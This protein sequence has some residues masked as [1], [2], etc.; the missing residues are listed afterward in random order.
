MSKGLKVESLLKVACTE[1]LQVYE[2]NRGDFHSLVEECE[3]LDSVQP[4]LG[5][6]SKHPLVVIELASI[7]EVLKVIRNAI[8]ADDEIGEDE[9]EMAREV[10]EHS[11]YRLSFLDDY[12]DFE[13]LLDGQEVLDL[14]SQW[15]KDDSFYGGA[16]TQAGVLHS[17]LRDL[18][19]A[20]TLVSGDMSIF[21]TVSQVILLVSR[22]IISSDGISYE[23][24]EYLDKLTASYRNMQ[25]A[26]QNLMESYHRVPDGHEY[27]IDEVSSVT[28]KKRESQYSPPAP[29]PAEV[30]EKALGELRSLVGVEEVKA[31]V[32]RLVNFLKVRQQRIEAGLPMAMQSLHFVFTGN[33]G[34]GKTTVA[35]ILG[36]ILYGFGLLKT[37]TFVE[38]DRAGLVGG[39]VGQTAIKTTEVIAKAADGVLFID[40]AY[41]LSSNVGSGDQ[42]GQ[43]AIDV[44]LKKM[45]DM[46][47]RLVVIVAGYP[48]LM[49]QFLLSNPGLESRFTRFINF[50]DYYVSD[51]CRIFAGMAKNNSYKLTTEARGN[52]ALLFNRAFQTKQQNFGNA[53]FVRNV[54][55]QT[56]GNH[57][58]RLSNHA[59][60]VT[61]EMLMTIE[62]ADLPFE[63][64]K[65]CP[66]PF[67]LS[68]SRWRG[69]C[70][71]CQKEAAGSLKLLG[72]NVRCKCGATFEYPWWN[73]TAESLP[74]TCQY[75]D[76]SRPL[77][78]TGSPQAAKT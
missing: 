68:A 18:A 35:R 78:L 19:M 28:S 49:R 44:L 53:R 1:I 51:L 36:K 32:Q 52:L 4:L 40:E 71:T 7:A 50:T 54:Y 20:A 12:S 42:Y 66:G 63:M 56:L 46:R 31:E 25:E 39:Y 26:V 65:G 15:G 16:H 10:L 76:L 70:P 14:L 9:L 45:E 69:A 11:I 73:A 5:T 48:D 43:E 57:A 24:R 72:Q 64:I 60:E 59:G 8:L 6:L 23:E 34:T 17:P 58:D 75:K 55:E 74:A 47:D 77:D 67:D 29:S 38:T 13:A 41:T 37:D 2:G 33:P 21:E 3:V 62:A 30:L 61:R 22:L 27:P